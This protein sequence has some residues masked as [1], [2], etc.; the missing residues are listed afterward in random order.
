M[1][2]WCY[3]ERIDEQVKVDALLAVWNFKLVYNKEETVAKENNVNHLLIA[4][5]DVHEQLEASDL[6][7][8]HATADDSQIT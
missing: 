5:S 2:I 4:V 6:L 8:P 1:N 3:C 7:T